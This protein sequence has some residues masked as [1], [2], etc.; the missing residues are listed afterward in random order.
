MEVDLLYANVVR[1]PYFATREKWLCCVQMRTVAVVIGT[2]YE[3]N[4]FNDT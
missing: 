2:Q 1:V 4:Q 3:N